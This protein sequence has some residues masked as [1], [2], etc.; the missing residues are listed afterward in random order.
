[1]FTMIDWRYRF[2]HGPKDQYRMELGLYKLGHSVDHI[3]DRG[4]EAER[5][6]PTPLIDHFKKLMASPAEAVGNLKT[7]V[8]TS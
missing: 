8:P 4:M 2:G 6:E 3:G 7:E 1:M 5:W